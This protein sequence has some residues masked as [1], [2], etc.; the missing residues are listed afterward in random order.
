M[1]TPPVTPGPARSAFCPSPT[2]PVAAASCTLQTPPARVLLGPRSQPPRVAAGRVPNGFCSHSALTAAF[3]ERR[4]RSFSRS[5]S[6]PTPMKADTSHDSR[7][8]R[9]PAPQAGPPSPEAPVG[10]QAQASSSRM[11]RLLR[12]HRT[13]VYQTEGHALTPPVFWVGVTKGQGLLSP[14]PGAPHAGD[15]QY[16]ISPWP[17]PQARWAGTETCTA[18]PTGLALGP[19]AFPARRPPASGSSRLALSL[20]VL[21]ALV[22]LLAWRTLWDMACWL[23]PLPVSGGAA[24]AGT[25]DGPQ[26]GGTSCPPGSDLQSSHCTLGEAFEDLDWETEKGLEAVACDTEGFVPPKVMVRPGAATAQ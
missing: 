25:A 10:P 8:S 5:W 23:C 24:R 16:L 18:A 7:D 4:E 6:D 12:F 2:R 3:A 20:A 13:S 19:T 15:L 1:Q 26:P 21:T 22:F 14:L 9:C 17:R 11:A